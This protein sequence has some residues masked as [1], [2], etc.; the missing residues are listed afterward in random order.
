MHKQTDILMKNLIFYLIVGLWSIPLLTQAQDTPFQEFRKEAE[1]FSMI[2]SGKTVSTYNRFQYYNLPYWETE[3]YR[4]GTLCYQGRIYTDVPLRYDLYQNELNILLPKRIGVNVDKRKVNYF[5]LNKVMFVP[6]EG[7]YQLILHDG[8]PLKLTSIIRCVFGNEVQE[9]TSSFKNFVFKEQYT[10]TIDGKEY[11][12]KNKKSF[13][14]CFPA[15]K[16]QL[17]KYAKEQAL[18]FK[19]HR[20]DAF[21]AMTQYAET[22]IKADRHEQ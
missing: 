8:H 6:Y 3:E 10:L 2:Y 11:E 5:I 17:K 18:D 22:L 1:D 4:N 13:I 7:G 19:T 15:Y 12:V 20:K 9:G 21:I 16:K 14:K